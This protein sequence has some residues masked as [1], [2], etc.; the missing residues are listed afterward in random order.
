MG[1]GAPT[2]ATAQT[3]GLGLERGL[4]RGPGR[5]GISEDRTHGA[6]P[7]LGPLSTAAGEPPHHHHASRELVLE[8]K[9]PRGRRQAD[10]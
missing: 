10:Q 5:G 7:A 9:A 3:G 8:T 1:E 4:G 6:L 2:G